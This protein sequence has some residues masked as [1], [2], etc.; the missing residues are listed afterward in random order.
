MLWKKIHISFVFFAT[1]LCFLSFVMLLNFALVTDVWSCWFDVKTYLLVVITL[2]AKKKKR[3]KKSTEKSRQMRNSFIAFF[4]LPPYFF[5]LPSSGPNIY[6]IEFPVICCKSVWTAGS[7]TL[8][9]CGNI[10][11]IRDGPK[12]ADLLCWRSCVL[13]DCIFQFSLKILFILNSQLF[14]TFN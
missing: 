11:L 6:E 2:F 14:E 7:C 9:S 10:K 8:H 4:P 12:C 5:H 3:K 13:M 1:L